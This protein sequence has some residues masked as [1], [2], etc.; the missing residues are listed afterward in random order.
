MILSNIY[1]YCRQM[2]KETII[3]AVI[4]ILDECDNQD[5][6]VVTIALKT[7]ATIIDSRNQNIDPLIMNQIETCLVNLGSHCDHIMLSLD[8]KGKVT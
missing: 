8:E 5:F 2:Y 4:A 7:L 6:D 1:G 3:G